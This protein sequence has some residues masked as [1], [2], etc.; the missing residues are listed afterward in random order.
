MIFQYCGFQIIFL[1]LFFRPFHRSASVRTV[2]SA[3]SGQLDPGGNKR[4][5]GSSSAMAMTQIPAPGSSVTLKRT[6]WQTKGGA[7]TNGTVV[8]A[9]ASNGG[10]VNTLYHG[11][12]GSGVTPASA[13]ATLASCAALAAAYVACGAALLSEAQ[14]WG[15]GE[16]AYFC[17][18]ALCT[19]GFG[20]LRPE[21][22]HLAPC[23]AYLFFGLAVLS[24][25]FHLLRDCGGAPGPGCLRRGP[26]GRPGSLASSLESLGSR[27]CG[28]GNRQ[29]RA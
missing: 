15:L 13:A 23:V 17:F 27:S 10:S 18:V 1:F 9:S 29:G 20:G 21:D 6:T 3:R 19:V 8:V 7:G 2:D 28:G 4:S 14:G 16:A 25:C 11:S 24:T 22:P 5:S 26:G 12:D